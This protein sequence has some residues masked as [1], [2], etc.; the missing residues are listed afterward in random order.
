MLDRRRKINHELPTRGDQSNGIPVNDIPKRTS[1]SYFEDYRELSDK[2]TN[3]IIEEINNI[4][5]AGNKL[6]IECYKIEISITELE[7]SVQGLSD[8]SLLKRVEK[9]VKDLNSKLEVRTKILNDYNSLN[10]DEL[11]IF[12]ADKLI[13]NDVVDINNGVKN[14]MI[15]LRRYTQGIIDNSKKSK[16]GNKDEFF[17]IGSIKDFKKVPQIPTK[18]KIPVPKN[19]NQVNEIKSFIKTFITKQ[20]LHKDKLSK[21][22]D[23]YKLNS[24]N[25]EVRF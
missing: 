7:K 24:N 8:S 15:S 20:N 14:R 13:G 4:R 9:K 11:S 18:S 6:S 3:Y 21:A 19:N 16:D 5:Y 25:S 2:I 1:N 22:F 10:D 23:L 17:D 12:I